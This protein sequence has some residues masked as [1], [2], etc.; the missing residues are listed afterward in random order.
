MEKSTHTP[1]YD[2]FR[3]R[4]AEMRKAAKLT[5]RQL[6]KRLEREHSFVA[7]FEIGDR[8]LDV[9]EFFW[10]CRACGHNACDVAS[11]LMNAFAEAEKKKPTWTATQQGSGFVTSRGVRGRPRY[12]PT[13]TIFVE[14]TSSPS[15]DHAAS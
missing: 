15:M 9:V 6:A 8:R 7:R 11:E 4:L 5:Q 14:H 12:I 1:L 3:A 13:I 2:L 10:I